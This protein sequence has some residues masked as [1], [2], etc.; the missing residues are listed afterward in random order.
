[1]RM[2]FNNLG[3]KLR[4][5]VERR[6]D[7]RAFDPDSS[8]PR[9]RGPREV[10]IQTIDRCNATCIMCPYSSRDKNVPTHIIDDGLYR[11]ILDQASRFDTLLILRLMLQNEPLIDRKLPE[12]VKLA[13]KVLGPRVRIHTVTNGSPLTT[14]MIDALVEA[15]IDRVSVSIDAASEETFAKIR[16][17]LNYKQVVENTL[18]L[19]D[20]GGPRRVS[21]KFLRQPENE[22][23][24][25]E[26]ARFWRKQGVR[27]KFSTPTN[28][29][30]AVEG[31][32][33]VKKQ[34]DLFMKLGYPILN[35]FVSSC[36][37]PFYQL[38]VLWD[39]RAITCANDW[40][41]RDT[42]GNLSTETLEEI[43]YGDK[44]NHY[45]RMLRTG[46]A[47]ESRVCSGCSQSKGFWNL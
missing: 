44:M 18:A 11:R 14:A 8:H 32:E 35:R 37:L 4:R 13:K 24:E 12:R 21:V 5:A 9:V 45:R 22:G 34:P 40:G 31:Y 16:E 17:G 23:E 19:I 29:S 42:V 25:G 47:E 38:C 27:L 26:F 30:G 7:V 39:G 10:Q 6:R 46:R 2:L 41:P 20:R 36:P 28:R 33:T 15:D 3:F 1:M 43:W